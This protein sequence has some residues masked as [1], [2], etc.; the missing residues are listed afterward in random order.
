MLYIKIHSF[1]GLLVQTSE[2]FLCLRMLGARKA[3]RNTAG[4]EV[5]RNPTSAETLQL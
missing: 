1:I 5:T 4:S 3:V 2:I